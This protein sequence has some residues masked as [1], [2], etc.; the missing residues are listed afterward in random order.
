MLSHI[1]L[2]SLTFDQ[3]DPPIR[4]REDSKKVLC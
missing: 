3:V 4:K 1:I 2:D